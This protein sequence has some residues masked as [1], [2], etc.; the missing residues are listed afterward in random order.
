MN[1]QKWEDL[2]IGLIIAMEGIQKKLDKIAV[3]I[4][5]ADNHGVLSKIAENIKLKSTED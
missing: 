1:E 4:D 3:A 2:F 5:D